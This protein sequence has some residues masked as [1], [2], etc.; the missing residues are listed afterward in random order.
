MLQ[1]I[2]Q[3]QRM[4]KKMI[5]I[6]FGKLNKLEQ[7]IHETLSEQI[8]INDNMRITEAAETCDCSTSKISKFVK[9]LGFDN[10][11]QYLDFLQ[12][13]DIPEQNHTNELL[14]IHNF[15]ND[16]DD[17]MAEEML[18]LIEKHDKIVLFGYGP[19]LICA[20]YFEYRLRLFTSKM[21]IAV[22]DEV[23]VASMT[24]ESTLLILITVTGK[25]QS[26]QD[27]YTQS[28]EKGCDVVMVVENTILN[29]LVSVIKYFGYLNIHNPANC[30]HM[31]NPELYFLFS[32]R[33][34]FSA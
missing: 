8:K 32:L 9:K 26:F 7:K 27:V 6:D 4:D 23:S 21:I 3:I 34:L 33:K 10:Y 30:F 28:K 20:Q 16:F 12:G 17:L 18:E 24:N 29:F 15:I 13:R 1:L 31:K 11:K 25:F 19:S 2:L 14:R 22:A 5:N